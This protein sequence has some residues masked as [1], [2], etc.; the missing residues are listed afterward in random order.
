MQ[1]A[2]RNRPSGYLLTTHEAHF[3]QVR[4]SGA[5]ASLLLGSKTAGYYKLSF[6][7]AGLTR[8][9]LVSANWTKPI[10]A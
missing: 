8:D 10:L 3:Y 9:E 6:Q 5:H 2:K 7:T 4:A 1:G